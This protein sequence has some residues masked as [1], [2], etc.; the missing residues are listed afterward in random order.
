MV[1]SL[2][3][4]PPRWARLNKFTATTSSAGI[5]Q[6]RPR[7]Y[8]RIARLTPLAEVLALIDRE[9]KPVAPRR[10]APAQAW[11]ATL[12]ADVVA[13]TQP[14]APRALIDGWALNAEP[15][16]DAGGYAPAPLPQMPVLVEAGR[17]MPPGADSVATLDAVKVANGRAEA[18]APV[19]P[20]DGVLPA[21][22]RLRCRRAAAPRRRA[23]ACRRCCRF[24][25]CRRR[26]SQRADAAATRRARSAP[27]RSSTPPRT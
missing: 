23:P 18:L 21:G 26:A 27:I 3:R 12:A 24:D 16:R 9:V 13:A 5:W 2:M 7:R 17:P 15:T 20:G 6:R 11:R 8:R 10:M 25:R 19:N 4:F 14:A 22:A 1:V